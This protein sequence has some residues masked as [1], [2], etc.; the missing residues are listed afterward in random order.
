MV[1]LCSAIIYSYY[2]NLIFVPIKENNEGTDIIVKTSTIYHI[3]SKIVFKLISF[4]AVFV[5]NHNVIIFKQE[6]IPP[7]PEHIIPL[8]CCQ[9]NLINFNIDEIVSQSKLFENNKLNTFY[10]TEIMIT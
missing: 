2:Y 6:F 10:L 9:N 1:L 5:Y 3:S 4:T 7:N 8:N